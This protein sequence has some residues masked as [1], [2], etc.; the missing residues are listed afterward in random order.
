MLFD[1]SCIIVIYKSELH[2]KSLHE[3]PV[4]RDTND[5]SRTAR[6]QVDF[7]QN[8]LDDYVVRVLV[9]ATDERGN[10]EETM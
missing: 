3:R 10:K 8:S 6:N 5:L 1:F 9:V 7:I 2:W 4:D